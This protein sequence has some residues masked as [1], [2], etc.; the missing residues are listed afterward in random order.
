MATVRITFRKKKLKDGSFPIVIRLQHLKQ[1]TTFIRVQGLSIT[2]EN[3][4]EMELSRFTRN[5]KEWKQ[6]NKVI[7]EIEEKIEGISAK[8]QAQNNF[9]YQK[10][11]DVYFDNK[12][13]NLVFETFDQKIK[14]LISLKKFGTCDAY[15]ASM[16][17]LKKFT[18]KNRLAFSDIDFL[19]LSNFEKHLRLKGNSGNTISYKIRSLRA[20][21]YNYCN[22]ADKPL[23][24]AYR[25]FKVGRLATVTAKRSLT[26][27][28]L[29]AF[30][31]YTPNTLQ[32]QMSKDIFV[33]SL[34]T[35]GMN[36]ADMAFLKPSN[37]I[38]GRIEY[39]RAKTGGLF[40]VAI[41]QDIQSIL[42]RLTKGGEWLFPIIL[43]H[44][45]NSRHSI[46]L[47]TRFMNSHLKTISTKLEIPKITTYWARHTFAQLSLE[48]GASVSLIS[49]SL[50]HADLKTTQIY[51]R[52][53]EN[54]ELD[55][56]SENIINRL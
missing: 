33:F 6:L 32:E 43:P 39:R 42:D 18:N 27:E 35:R 16:R 30:M 37:L 11:R 46:W 45:K 7:T 10:F 4:W 13:S 29:K 53:F 47:F 41:T 36:I 25:K 19:F 14:D 17:A 31:K 44:H 3:E 12:V 55:N 2:S 21:H 15:T 40:S 20:L 54:K 28:E 24:S 8:L 52:G 51:L 38:D 1:S 50:G 34:L 26:R 22:A 56:L 5:K 9:S 23:P 48:S 49:A